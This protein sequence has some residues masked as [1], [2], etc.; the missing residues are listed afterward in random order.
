MFQPDVKW[1]P[2][3]LI[4]A[5]K[6]WSDLRETRTLTKSRSKAICLNVAKH[7]QATWIPWNLTKA[8]G[9]LS[10]TDFVVPNVQF[11]EVDFSEGALPCICA[12]V[13]FDLEFDRRFSSPELFER[14]Q[15][16]NDELRWAVTFQ[17]TFELPDDPFMIHPDDNREDVTVELLT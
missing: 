1:I 10:Q 12:S 7:I 13:Q 4:D 15:E 2:A 11:E 8:D 6:R 9:L 3:E 5:G 14:W 16:E 17:Y